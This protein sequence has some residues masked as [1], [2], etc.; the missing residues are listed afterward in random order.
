MAIKFG[1]KQELTTQEA[2]QFLKIPYVSF[3]KLLEKGDIPYHEVNS[4]KRIRLEDL[5]VYKQ[6]RDEQR[7]QAK[8]ELTAFLE[9]EGFYDEDDSIDEN[10]LS[11]AEFDDLLN[12]TQGIWTQG[13]GLAYQ[14]TLRQEWSKIKLI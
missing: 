1:M 10:P 8:R 6:K 7:R 14:Q 12:E 3:I 9:E 13:D 5:I 2:A 11:D 4:S